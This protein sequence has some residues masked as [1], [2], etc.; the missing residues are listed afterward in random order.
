M[1]MYKKIA[2]A[3]CACFMAAVLSGC[4]G[5]SLEE[6][7]DQLGGRIDQVG[8]EVDQFGRELDGSSSSDA[9][10]QGGDGADQASV[11]GVTPEF[12]EA[13]DSYET[14]FDE[15]VAFMKEYSESGNPASM[16]AEYSMYMQQYA[17][18]MAA[19]SEIDKDTLSEADALYL[20]E[21]SGCIAT[22]TAGLL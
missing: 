19:I 21:V 4:G 18:T 11:D 2:V 1:K 22:K 13:M 3:A 5:Q 16:V 12:K 8:E 6:E 7:V 10:K 20:A 9:A 15:Y 17:E 14:F